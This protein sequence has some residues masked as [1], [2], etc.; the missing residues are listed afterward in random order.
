MADMV[1]AQGIIIAINDDD[2]YDPL[3]V[4]LSVIFIFCV[5]SFPKD[6]LGFLECLTGSVGRMHDS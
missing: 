1:T 2:N 5:P 4:I 3:F 6:P